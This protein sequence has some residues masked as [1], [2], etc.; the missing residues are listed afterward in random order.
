MKNRSFPVW[1]NLRH[2]GLCRSWPARAEN[3]GGGFRNLNRGA[4]DITRDAA[5]LP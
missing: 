3:E 1:G 2:A 4:K 5:E